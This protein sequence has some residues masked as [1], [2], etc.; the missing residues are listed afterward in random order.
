MSPKVL[1]SDPEQVRMAFG[2]HLE[3]LRWRLIKALAAIVIGVCLAAVFSSPITTFFTAPYKM[4]AFAEGTSYP[5]VARHPTEVFMVVTKLCVLVGVLISSPYAFYQIWAFVA[6][7]LYPRERATVMR[8]VPASVILFAVGVAFLFYVVLPVTLRVLMSMNSWVPMPDVQPPVAVAPA[9]QAVLPRIPVLAID[10]VDAPVGS[11]WVNQNDLRLKVVL[12]NQQIF[13]SDLHIKDAG[14]VQ[15][16][17]DLDQY[18]SFV[19]GLAFAF[20]LGFQVPLVVM[21]L[22]R[23]GIVS[24]RRMAKARRIVVLVVFVSAAIVTPTPDIYNMTL[25][26]VP[27]LLLFEV[28]LLLARRGE[29]MNPPLRNTIFD[30]DDDED[31]DQ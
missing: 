21:L 4:A 29:K 19:T 28:G 12:E 27:M 20:G 16:Q 5:L 11:M 18:V 23:I 13:V 3:E 1:P 17:F 14:M 7:G 22:S 15:S 2:D 9:T 26:A 30:I 10:P 31:A 24:A 25:L 6:A 8:M